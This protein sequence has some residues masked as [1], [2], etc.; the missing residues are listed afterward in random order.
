MRNLLSKGLMLE[1]VSILILIFTIIFSLLGKYFNLP[2]ETSISGSIGF[3]ITASII[4]LKWDL[5]KEIEQK[6]ELY[7]ILENITDEDLYKKGLTSIQ[8]CKTELEN[9]SKGILKI[10]SG[11]LFRY[12]IQ[13]SD[14]AKYSIKTTHIG[15]DE[16][17]VDIWE[18]AGE[19]Q[20]YSFNLK[21]VKKG[22][23]FERFF[24][25]QKKDVYSKESTTITPKIL[26]LLKKQ[27][28]DGIQVRVIWHEEVDNLELIQDFYICDRNVALITQPDW[29]FGYSNVVIHKQS[30]EINKYLGIYETLRSISHDLSEFEK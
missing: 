8:Q 9:L 19:Q 25:L 1:V 6:L 14:A 29:N 16:K 21:L 28:D 10:G 27:S 12:L 23:K 13:L 30:H 20:W 17:Y 22:I 15:I 26:N 3:A 11:Q 18:T 7:S 2:L 24:I 5:K 4:A